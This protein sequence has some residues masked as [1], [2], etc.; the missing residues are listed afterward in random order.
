MAYRESDLPLFPD[1]Y[2]AT[3][4]ARHGSILKPRW[5]AG[6][7]G[8]H[9]LPSRSCSSKFPL[10]KT[11]ERL[12]EADRSGSGLPQLLLSVDQ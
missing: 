11:L 2:S 7:R 1:I 9:P 8:L 3:T 6:L 4:A 12:G 5:R 10:Q